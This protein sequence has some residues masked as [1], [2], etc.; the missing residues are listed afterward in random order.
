MVNLVNYSYFVLSKYSSNP[1]AAQAFLA[2]LSTSESEDKYL[3]NFAYY[4]P[5][6]TAF[7]SDLMNK[8]ISKTFDRVRYQ[9]FIRDGVNLSLF[10]K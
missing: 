9:S 6:Q 10:D 5:A 7:E 1:D 2:Y 8:S 3:K 4:L